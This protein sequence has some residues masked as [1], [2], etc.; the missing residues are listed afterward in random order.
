[1]QSPDLLFRII[2]P[3]HEYRIYTSGRVEGFGSNAKVVNRFFQCSDLLQADR[4]EELALPES[5]VQA[6]DI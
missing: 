3:G 1:M 4:T 2:V 5:K 6:V